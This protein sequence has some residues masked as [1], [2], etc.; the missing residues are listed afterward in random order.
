MLCLAERIGTGMGSNSSRQARSNCQQLTC[1][2]DDNQLA[3]IATA[4]LQCRLQYAVRVTQNGK[5]QTLAVKF[6]PVACLLC[7]NPELFSS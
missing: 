6:Q 4:K 7:V 3:G 2:E 5:M 1:L